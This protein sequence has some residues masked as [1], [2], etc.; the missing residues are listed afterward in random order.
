MVGFH[1]EDYCTNFIECCQRRLG[2]RVDHASGHVEFDNRTVHVRPLPIGI[3]FDYFQQLAIKAT[4]VSGPFFSTSEWNRL[5][6]LI[7]LYEM[8]KGDER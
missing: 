5:L 4:R 3:P 7:F 6:C 2:C 1:I 8:A